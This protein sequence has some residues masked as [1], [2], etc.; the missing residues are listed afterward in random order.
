LQLILLSFA[1][2]DSDGGE[3]QKQEGQEKAPNGPLPLI[4]ASSSR[5]MSILPRKE[6]GHQF[7][8][9]MIWRYLPT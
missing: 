4:S 1:A 7:L 5:V 3:E 9:P 2:E 6:E 8:I